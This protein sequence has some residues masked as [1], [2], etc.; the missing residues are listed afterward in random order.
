MADVLMQ[1]TENV[2]PYAFDNWKQVYIA[3]QVKI[4]IILKGTSI[5]I[6]FDK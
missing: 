2:H 1:L 3:V 5:R 4:G 6:N